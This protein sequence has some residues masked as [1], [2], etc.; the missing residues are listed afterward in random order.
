MATVEPELRDQDTLAPGTVLEDRYEILRVCGQGGMSTVY[1]ARDLRFSH[2]ERLCAIKE[3]VDRARDHQTRMLRLANFEREASLLATLS[4]PAIPKIYDYFSRSGLIYLVLEFIDGED[5]EHVISRAQEPI[6]EETLIE[7]SDQIL[8]VLSYLHEHQPEPIV[9]RDLKPSN[10]MLRSDGSISLIDFGIART[11]QPLQRGT[12][13]GTEGYAPPEQY[14]GISEPRGDVY[15]MGATLHH[16]STRSDPRTEPPFTFA[17][18]LPREINTHLTAEFESVVLRAVA[19]SPADRFPSAAAMQQAL[20]SIGEITSE[21]A[22]TATAPRDEQHDAAEEHFQIGV[23]AAP[24]VEKHVDAVTV[25]DPEE[26]VLWTIQTGDEV[27]GTATIV[28]DFGYIGSYDQHLYA[29]KAGDGGITWRFRAQRG[30]VS[31]PLA[32]DG[33]IIIGSED[34]C[35]Y[36]IHS[37]TGRSAWSFRT[38]MPI[39]S[40]AVQYGDAV[41]IGSDDGYC[42]CLD[43]EQGHLLWRQ[44]AWGPIRSSA[45]IADDVIVT[46]SDDGALH[47]FSA[48]DGRQLWRHQLGREI[49]SSPI[50]RD[51][52]VVVG[53]NDGGLYAVDLETGNRI[54]TVKTEGPVIASPRIVSDAVIVGSVDGKV[55][56]VGLDD[57]A[58]RWVNQ[59]ATQITSS[60]TIDGRRGYVG[61]V[62]GYVVC[63]NLESGEI[64]WSHKL[65]SPIVSTPV[66]S[67]SM[68]FVGAMNGRI[69]AVRA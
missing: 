34:H 58:V 37:H 62:D 55:H 56:A 47:A 69:Y 26:R 46:G 64:V 14:R 17:Q 3:M 21:R 60:V 4:H 38:A 43:I 50:V 33:K 31:R 40:S 27:R 9:F 59:I 61:T 20:S 5:L 22:S 49:L 18:R 8:D 1:A 63:L 35:V 12:M 68:L 32:V 29:F 16:L 25:V 36:A 13:I 41:I 11:F 67:G 54:W 66:K 53:C 51:G 15:A 52:I 28:G 10:I 44:R 45:A 30:I 2:V 7:W 24:H 19:Y 39:R 42:Y 6:D 23:A 65:G 57:G 48:V